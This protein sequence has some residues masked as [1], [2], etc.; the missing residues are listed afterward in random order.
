MDPAARG[1][2]QTARGADGRELIAS[3]D[4]L[5]LSPQAGPAVFRNALI[6]AQRRSGASGAAVHA[7]SPEEY[8]GMRLFL[9]ADGNAGFA[10]KGDDIVSVF[11][12]RGADEPAQATIAILRLAVEQGGR[13]LDAFETQLPRL[14]SRGGFV[15]ESRIPFSDANRP[16]GWD[17][18]AMRAFNG[19]RPDVVFMVYDPQRAA[20]QPYRE[21]QSGQ[22]FTAEQ[23]DE[24]AAAQQAAVAR[25]WGGRQ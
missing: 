18:E 20:A 25:R 21:R 10:L 22:A 6:E 15:V 3:P 13:R 14:Y 4:F 24:A 23:Y 12:T 5:E 19:G 17:Y 2:L 11:A 16:E 9:S 7:Y 1:E 8:A